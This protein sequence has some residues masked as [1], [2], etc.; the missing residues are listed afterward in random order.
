MSHLQGCPRT[1]LYPSCLKSEIWSISTEEGGPQRQ[2]QLALQDLQ[3][4]GKRK[5]GWEGR[6]GTSQQQ[7]QSTIHTRRSP[8]SQPAV[9]ACSHPGVF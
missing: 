3:G 5:A 7:L 8:F 2:Q 6:R 4:F 1:G 9:R